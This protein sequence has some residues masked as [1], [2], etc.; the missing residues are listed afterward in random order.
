M[1]SDDFYNINIE[2]KKIVLIKPNHLHTKKRNKSRKVTQ[3]LTSIVVDDLDEEKQ[4]ISLKEKKLELEEKELK[5]E[6]EKLE[7]EKE[8]LEIFKSK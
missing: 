8:R 7:L 4:I 2:R 1:Q 6:K 5:L 3:T